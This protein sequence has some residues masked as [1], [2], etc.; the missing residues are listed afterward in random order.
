MR[1][2]YRFHAEICRSIAH[3][4]RLEILNLLREG[5]RSVGE[6]AQAM[7]ITTA[8]ASQ[9]LTVLRNAGVIRRSQVGTMAYY[10]IAD[11]RVLQAYDL[12]SEVVEEQYARRAK[13]ISKLGRKARRPGGRR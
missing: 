3:P 11:R 8:N 13:S 1:D 5:P 10:E 9:Q 12:M 6:L 2:A 4:K 7:E